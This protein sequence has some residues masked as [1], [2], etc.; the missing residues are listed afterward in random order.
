MVRF[1]KKFF[2]VVSLLLWITEREKKRKEKEEE[3]SLLAKKLVEISKIRLNRKENKIR[4][5]GLVSLSF[6]LM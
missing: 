4:N 5:L 3:Y 2:A 1:Q 6:S